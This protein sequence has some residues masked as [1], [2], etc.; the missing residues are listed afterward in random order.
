[1]RLYLVRHGQDTLNKRGGWS[2]EPLTEEGVN[3][4]ESLSQKIKDI[5]FDFIIASDLQRTVQTANIIRNR[6]LFSTEIILDDCLREVNNGLLAGMDNDVA[7]ES[8]PGLFWNTLEW[9]ESY[10]QGESPSQ[11]YERICKWYKN[12]LLKHHNSSNV[13]LV[14]HQ[15]VIEALLCIINNKQFSNKKV[16]YKIKCGQMIMEVIK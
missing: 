9:E 12:F 15:G 2:Q 10:P 8:F 13:L 6:L 7:L 3:E 1:M 4:V 16:H 11:F 5:E 14:T